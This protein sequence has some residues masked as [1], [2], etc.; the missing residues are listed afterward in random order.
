MRDVVKYPSVLPTSG[1]TG[2][3]LFDLSCSTQ[4]LHYQAKIE[5]NFSSALLTLV[6]ED[7]LLL[8]GQLTVAHLMDSGDMVVAPVADSELQQRRLQ[9][10]TA[11]DTT[12]PTL[13]Q[14]F[15]DCESPRV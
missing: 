10:L 15:V 12:L 8:A 4:G 6:M 5:S 11:E 9:L 1:N 14:T 7:D 13:I 2:R 3:D